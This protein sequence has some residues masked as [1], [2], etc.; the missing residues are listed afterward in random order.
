MYI[1]KWQLYIHPLVNHFIPK[2]E[3]NNEL[4]YEGLEN[5]LIMELSAWDYLHTKLYNLLARA[6]QYLS[7]V[8]GLTEEETDGIGQSRGDRIRK[9]T[10]GPTEVEYFDAMSD[11][12]GSLYSTYY[13]ALQPGG[14]IDEIKKQLCMLAERL[15]IYLPL[16]QHNQMVK[17]PKV[18]NRRNPGKLGG[19]NP[20][21]P[22]KG[23][24]N[25]IL[26]D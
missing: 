9:I 23:G 1:N 6:G 10:T 12:I 20:T 4:Y 17:V 7:N 16:C 11:S 14:L 3:Y 24:E 19:P 21:Y 18:V 13:K 8:T 26:D 2:E 5:Q 15:E 22:I 25:I